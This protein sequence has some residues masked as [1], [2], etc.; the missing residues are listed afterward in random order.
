MY[1]FLS[2]Y[3]G[4][5]LNCSVLITGK[6]R[7]HTS[8]NILIVTKTYPSHT[9]VIVQLD[10]TQSGK[11]HLK[12]NCLLNQRIWYVATHSLST[13]IEEKKKA[14]VYT[15][16]FFSISSF[17]LA[18]TPIYGFLFL[19][20]QTAP[21]CLTVL[22]SLKELRH[23]RLLYMYMHEDRIIQHFNSVVILNLVSKL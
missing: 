13:R 1:I 21:V 7:K 19:T 16:F 4:Y 15:K 3:S 14:V 18:P 17:R 11:L 20:S 8:N 12:I 9:D 23:V 6:K 22:T 10:T 5:Y 2:T